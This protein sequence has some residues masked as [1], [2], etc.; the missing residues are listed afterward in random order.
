MKRRPSGV[1]RGSLSA[2]VGRRAG[3]LLVLS[4]VILALAAGAS[5][6]SIPDTNGVI[7]GCYSNASG[8]L[9]VI[10]S[11]TQICAATETALPWNQTGP[12]GPQGPSGPSG[13]QGPS[14]PSGP[15]G[16]QGASG[17]SGPQGAVG[18]SGPQGDVGP[19]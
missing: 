8:T 17:P 2:A 15:S 1:S 14:G 4:V 7:H 6:A 5:Y 13:P 10:N 3:R 19:S 12:T 9:R 11:P 16:P 18:P